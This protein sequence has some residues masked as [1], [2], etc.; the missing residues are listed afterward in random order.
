MNEERSDVSKHEPVDDNIAM[1]LIGET[2]NEACPKT[3]RVGPETAG[4]PVAVHVSLNRC[5][6]SSTVYVMST[7]PIFA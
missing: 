2:A 3:D 6:F 7:C 5:A 1:R 4:P